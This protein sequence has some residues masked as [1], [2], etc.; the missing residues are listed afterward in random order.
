MS[1]E[2]PAFTALA[3]TLRDALLRDACLLSL[4]EISRADSILVDVLAELRRHRNTRS[5]V[6]RLPPELLGRIFAHLSPDESQYVLYD[7]PLAK[8]RKRLVPTTPLL[9]VTNVYSKWRAVSLSTPSLWTRIDD[10]NP[11][12]LEAFLIRS[13]SMPVSLC[14]SSLNFP[15]MKTRLKSVTNRL[16]RLDVSPSAPGS[17]RVDISAHLDFEAPMLECLT[18]VLHERPRDAGSGIPRQR[19]LS[20]GAH[21]PLR[22]LAMTSPYCWLPGDRFP[23]LTHLDLRHVSWDEWKELAGFLLTFLAHTPVLQ[24]LHLANIPR[25][26]ATQPPSSPPI[27]ILSSLRA[28]LLSGA[29]ADLAFNLFKL[30]EFPNNVRLRLEHIHGLERESV[31]SYAIALAPEI[32][33]LGFT[34]MDLAFGDK[35][36]LLVVEGRESGFWIQ[37]GPHEDEDTRHWLHAGMWISELHLLLPVHA[38]EALRVSA[39]WYTVIWG[40][41]LARMVGLRALLVIVRGARVSEYVHMV[42]GILRALTNPACCP[43]LDSLTLCVDAAVLDKWSPSE[44]RDMLAARAHGNASLRHVVLEFSGQGVGASA[45]STASFLR[46]VEG[47]FSQAE[48]YVEELQIV[49]REGGLR[50]LVIRDVWRLEGFEKYWQIPSLHNLDATMW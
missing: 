24:Y 46:D 16:R 11:R 41:L 6:D 43:E 48:E 8:T 4:K 30:I 2:P 35:G 15:S 36:I 17:D 13:K 21:S 50:S 23:H 26:L 38:I 47:A 19:V 28:L 37:N 25:T 3:A 1:E 5:P 39:T 44:L 18:L 40:D 34:S 20:W 27:V 42:H 33:A 9:I 32:L 7:P 31:R 10:H 14:L 49:V 45:D 29:E 22:A 12:E